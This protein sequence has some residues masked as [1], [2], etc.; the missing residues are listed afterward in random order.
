MKKN[1]LIIEDDPIMRLGMEHFLTSEGYN[2]SQC[3][4]GK[5]G[6]DVI[7][8]NGFDL[9]ITD[10][11]LPYH[12]GFEI[13]KKVKADRPKTGVIIITGFA[14]IKGAVQAI[15]EGAFDYIAKP[16]SNEE[17]LVAIERFFK[18][19][20]LEEEV[21]YLKETL[22]GK[23]E[24]ENIIGVSS[25]MKDVFDR[26]S[27]VAST[28]IPV[29][30]TGE[31]G[32]GKELVANAIHRLSKRSNK[33]FIKINCA[34]IPETLF[35]SELF[36]HEKGAFTGATE[37]RKGKFEFADGGTIFFDEIG[38][39]PL[40]LQA[41]FLR[42]LE[43]GIIT[44]LGGNFTIKIDVRCIYATSKDLKEHV[45]AGKF[46]EDLFYRINVVPITLP[47][48]R[49][50]KEDIPYL[51]E[52]FLKYFKEKFN[53]S[54][55]DIS[56]TAYDALLSYDYPGNVRELKH[57]IERA[58]VLSK[59]GNINLKHLPEEIS[60][61][62]KETSCLTISPSLYESIRCFEKHK[63]IKA[64]NE[65]GGRKIEAAQKLGISRKVLWK[66]IKEYGI[67]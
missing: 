46:R 10:L 65:T 54:Y 15:K 53:K 21:T 13:L 64:L 48:L 47:P 20:S 7:G 3:A 23:I 22:K 50:R 58:A 35:E 31:S 52:H 56:S 11:R 42:V 40:S 5:E 27:S 39:I 34:A 59:D 38:D 43:E 16:F 36:G 17:L 66:K 4:N 28:D 26:I 61:A 8:K 6:L 32:T 45:S 14:E 60:Q 12:D 33:H 30:I 1:I 44:R 62:I 19:S 2:V 67:E 41:K 29:L 18:F 57:A 49:E 24:F 37:M 63:I 51:I 9:V 55:L 25:V